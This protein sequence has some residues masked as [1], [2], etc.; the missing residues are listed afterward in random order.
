ML[1]RVL[2]E[3]GGPTARAHVAKTAGPRT[4]IQ[5]LQHCNVGH[6]VMTGR[7]AES[8][9]HWIAPWAAWIELGTLPARTNW[10]N[11]SQN[12]AVAVAVKEWQRPPN[13]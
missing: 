1:T 9:L 2:T 12:S 6:I 13:G 7:S 11:T 3:E 8:S 4:P 10:R 5:C